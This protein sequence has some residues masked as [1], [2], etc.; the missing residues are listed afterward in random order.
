MNVVDA[1]SKVIVDNNG[2]PLQDVRLIQA[3]I[4]G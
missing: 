1:I 4:I 3:V 2:K